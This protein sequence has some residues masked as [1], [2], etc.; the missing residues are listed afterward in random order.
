MIPS[1]RRGDRFICG[2]W[3]VVWWI[4]LSCCCNFNIGVTSFTTAPFTNYHNDL[5]RS[6]K[7]SCY[8]HLSSHNDIMTSTRSNLIELKMSVN[9]NDDDYG[10]DTQSSNNTN[11]GLTFSFIMSFCGAT[12]GPF[13]DSYHSAFGVLE[14]NHPITLQLWGVDAN[15]PALITAWWVPELFALAGFIIGW[16][17]IL[18]DPLLVSKEQLKEKACPSVPWILLGISFFTFQYYTSGELYASG[19]LDRTTIL[20]IMSILAGIGFVT[21]D[22]TFSGFLVSTATAIGGPL[23]EYGLIHY[24]HLYHYNDLGETGYFPLWIV[25]V[26]FLGGPAVGNLARGIFNQLKSSQKQQQ[27]RKPCLECN[28]TRVV[29]CPNCDNSSGYYV[30]YGKSVK[31]NCCKGRG[32]VICRS[33]FDQYNEDPS[34]I[35]S[36]REMMSRMPD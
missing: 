17:Y 34:D 4:F 2:I 9:D 30:T 7:R 13:L 5:C 21:L 6:H 35:E 1:S 22:N 25:P 19:A 32:Y 18:L 10:K 27:E 23:I 24:G 16:L 15:H 20:N 28:D 11:V 29:P 3:V 36:I 14:Y 12:L 33:C 31:C 8:D 26:Y